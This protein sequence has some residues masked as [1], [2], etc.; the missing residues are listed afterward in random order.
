MNSRLSQLLTA[1]VVFSIPA[2][3]PASDDAVDVEE[4]KRCINARA[5]R[6]TDVLN[7]G[8]VIFYMQGRKIYLN[9]LLKSCKG[10][11]L[12]GRFSFVTHTRSL[13]RLDSIN[14]LKDSG[15]GVYEG[16]ACK[17]GRFKSVTEEDIQDFYERLHKL[18][19]AEPTEL[20]PVQDVTG[21]DAEDAP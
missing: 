15:S 10:L 1:L 13:C 11:S 17:L 9:T 12:D 6:R 3:A 5:I 8:N 19:E 21:D 4:G 16:R 18:P 2:A 7:D 14:V 20:P